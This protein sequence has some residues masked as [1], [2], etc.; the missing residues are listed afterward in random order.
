MSAIRMTALMQKSSSNPKRAY[1]VAG[2]PVLFQKTAGFDHQYLRKVSATNYF[3]ASFTYDID[4]GR[5]RFIR[6][7]VESVD[8]PTP[9]AAMKWASET[10][11]HT[12][13]ISW[14]HGKMYV[15]K[16]ETSG[17]EMSVTDYS[18]IIHPS[19]ADDPNLVDLPYALFPKLSE[20][21]S[22]WEPKTNMTLL[23]ATKPIKQMFETNLPNAKRNGLKKAKQT[24]EALSKAKKRKPIRGRKSLNGIWVNNADLALMDAMAT[25]A[26]NTGAANILMVGPSGTGKTSLPKAFAE[27]K[28]MA[29]YK[30]DCALVADPEEFFGRREAKDGTTYFEKSEFLKVAEA[31][32][33]VIVLDEFNRLQPWLVNGLYGFLDDTHSSGDFKLGENVIFFATMN[34]G[35]RFTGTFVMD[36]AMTNRFDAVL[37]VTYPPQDVEEAII[38]ERVPELDSGMRTAVVNL[39][40][41]SREFENKNQTGLDVSVRST[42]RLAQAYSNSEELPM[43]AL[44]SY[45]IVGFIADPEVRKLYWDYIGPFL[46][47]VE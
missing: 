28:G 26:A 3:V 20:Y 21:S 17:D 16:F 27:S 2:P 41:K 18:F 1:F 47:S 43:R 44:V 35:S 37:E 11:E 33:A 15:N 9:A 30:M 38:K 46:P 19:Y 39:I 34:L 23:K 31:G 42:L 6:V 40:Q 8:I 4:S 22:G 13:Y 45:T 25:K 14:Q 32:N 29:F 7:Q 10:L 12:S 5:R 36:A 24:G